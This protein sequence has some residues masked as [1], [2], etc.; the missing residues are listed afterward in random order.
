MIILNEFCCKVKQSVKQLIKM[1]IVL[2]LCFFCNAYAQTSMHRVDSLKAE[3]KKTIND[4]IRIKV[5]L[6]L[7]EL[8]PCNDSNQRIVY[9]REA[10]VLAQKSK[11]EPA[12]INVLVATGNAYIECNHD[13]SRGVNS[14]AAA[15]SIAVDIE[16]TASIINIMQRLGFAAEQ[17]KKFKKAFEYFSFALSFHPNADQEMGIWGNMGFIC[18]KIGDYPKALKCYDR[19]FKLLD[20][21]MRI[22]G[23][24]DFS[25]TLQKGGLMICIGQIYVEKKDYSKA[26]EYYN[27][28]YKMSERS[29]ALNI[30]ALVGLGSILSLQNRYP[31]AIEN[32]K[33]ALEKSLKTG[34]K[35]ETIIICTD[36]ADIYLKI[37]DV[38]LAMEFGLKAQTIAEE[39]QDKEGLAS[40]YSILGKI[41]EQKKEYTLALFYLKKA[42]ALAELTESLDNQQDAWH[43]L[44][45][46]YDAIKQPEQALNAYKRYIALRD[47]LYNIDKAN[48]LTRI[49]LEAGFE[50]KQYA[51]SLSQSRLYEVKMQKQK[52]VSLSAYVGLGL[53]LLLSFFMYRNYSLQKKANILVNETNVKIKAEKQVSE[54]LLL[55]ILPEDV[56]KELKANGSVDARLFD[57][58][59]VLFTDFVNFTS[60][61]EQMT[62]KELVAELHS[63]FK[64]F[65]EITS[66][67]AIEKIKTVGDAYIAV[68]G[69]PV[70]NL[71]HGLEIVKAALEIRD[72]IAKRKMEIGDKAFDIRI[73]IN[74][75][76]VVAGI[77]GVKKFAY[78]IWGDTV[79]TAARMEQY[80]LPGKINLSANTYELVKDAVIC[81]ARG[82]IQ[83]KNKGELNM[84]FVEGLVG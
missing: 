71:G 64:A 61:G 36:L 44:S 32:Y 66:K 82:V 18:D 40:S 77:V 15:D 34:D 5:L 1:L 25:D 45:E 74:S 23:S 84:Y 28:V 50:R 41:Y 39:R 53:V 58:V 20:S 48:E 54:N 80:S 57:N 33:L 46:I 62:P 4:S 16:D 81:T 14:Y 76:T 78:D 21:S 31:E 13:Y 56:A 37:N 6:N 60:A 55:N 73:G 51:D 75:G 7:S 83:V 72:F 2:S 69:L 10:L 29:D 42:I 35:S 8:L 52:M 63:C 67:Y 17:F 59:T 70:S 22:S 9:A 38:A 43:S 26:Y 47:S 65:D 19:S 27:Q 68:S 79:N 12:E 3:L 30:M 24:A 49:D 11:M